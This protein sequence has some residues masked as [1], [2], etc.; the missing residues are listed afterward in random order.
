M[1]SNVKLPCG[2]GKNG[3]IIYIENAENGLKCDCV[4]PGCGQQLIAKNNGTKKEHHFAHLNV[5][6]CEHGYQSA[7]HY[8]AKDL[9]L[10]MKEFIFPKDGT[11]IK[12]KIDSV[13]L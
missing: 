11:P 6:E 12:Y 4:C 3:K 9:F 7:L 13:F 8:M 2:L 1:K 10:E 5:V